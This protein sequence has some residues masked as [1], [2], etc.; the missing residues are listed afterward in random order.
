[1]TAMNGPSCNLIKLPL[2][3]VEKLVDLLV[4]LLGLRNTSFIELIDF[5]IVPYGDAKTPI[6]NIAQSKLKNEQKK[7]KTLKWSF[8]TCGHRC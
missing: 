7:V 1:M 5:V 3:I 8:W 4:N 6:E 2:D